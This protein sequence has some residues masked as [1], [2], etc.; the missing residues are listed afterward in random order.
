MQAS[1]AEASEV[2]GFGSGAAAGKKKPGPKQQKTGFT[3]KACSLLL[4]ARSSRAL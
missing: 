1:Q 3:S 4:P 2:V